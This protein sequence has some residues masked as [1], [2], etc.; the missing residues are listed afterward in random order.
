MPIV[1]KYGVFKEDCVGTYVVLVFVLGMLVLLLMPLLMIT[2][3]SL[4][5]PWVYVFVGFLS[6]FL[7]FFLGFA[8]VV[9]HAGGARH[10]KL[11][12]ALEHVQL[13]AV[14][15]GEHFVE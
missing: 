1:S 2:V 7:P 4:L 10:R 13:A 15:F 14:A 6:P 8:R 12:H 3:L 11:H 9:C 5:M